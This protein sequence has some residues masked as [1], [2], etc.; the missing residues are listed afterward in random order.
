MRKFRLVT[1]ILVSVILASSCSSQ[2]E[3]SD[4]LSE[5]VPQQSVVDLG[6]EAT[7]E[8]QDSL[9]YNFQRRS[10]S[11]IFSFFVDQYG[12]TV[13]SD[14][15]YENLEVIARSWLSSEDADDLRVA[16][17][18]AVP[19][20]WET[21]LPDT[22]KAFVACGKDVMQS[23]AKWSVFL[24]KEGSPLPKNSLK[25]SIEYYVLEGELRE[26]EFGQI[27]SSQLQ[28]RI[29]ASTYIQIS[30]DNLSKILEPFAPD[31]YYILGDLGSKRHPEIWNQ[32]RSYSL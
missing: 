25:I 18:L 8:L 26:D 4:N 23:L 31:D 13:N 11:V 30:R 32:C 20:D 2:T 17:T 27:D 1:L 24:L 14:P 10:E 7:R 9:N 12:I 16:R 21:N 3:S 5:P 29:I 22:S 19:L 28:E 15:N 6:A